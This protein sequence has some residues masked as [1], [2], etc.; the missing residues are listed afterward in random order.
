V[1]RL[2]PT[3]ALLLVI[4][5]VAG[6][7]TR[8]DRLRQ[9]H[10]DRGP[11]AVVTGA[12]DAWIEGRRLFFRNSG[13]PAAE[14]FQEIALPGPGERIAA[15]G[16][17][18]YVWLAGPR[19]LEFAAGAGG[20]GSPRELAPDNPAALA[21][22]ERPVTIRPQAAAGR[23]DVTISP[24]RLFVTNSESGTSGSIPGDSVTAIDTSSNQVIGT[25]G[26][27]TGDSPYD[28]TVLPDNSQAFTANF[29]CQNC[30]D[31]GVSVFDPA[32]LTAIKRLPAALPS[33]LALSPDGTRLYAGDDPILRTFDT[34]TGNQIAALDLVVAIQS[35]SIPSNGQ[36]LYVIGSD[37]RLGDAIS[38]ISAASPG[39]LA[40]RYTFP[41]GSVCGPSAMLPGD[42][43]L[44]VVCNNPPTVYVINIQSDGT[45]SLA[46]SFSTTRA[47]S[48]AFSPDGKKLYLAHFDSSTLETLDAAAGSRLGLV[49][50][51]SG[52]VT[53]LVNRAGT[54][55]YTANY[56]AN[57]V[58]V[59]DLAS[60]TVLAS[61]AVG[62][63]P[64]GLAL[65]HAP[66]VVSA[67]P[68]QLSFTGAAGQANPAPQN[69][70]LNLEGSGATWG[71]VVATESGGNWL[72]LSAVN[73]TFPATLQ[74][75][76]NLAGLAGGVYSGSITVSP[77]LA[78]TT[79]VTVPVTLAVSAASGG[80]AV[81][82]GGIVNAASFAAGVPVAAG[83]LVSLFGTSLGP[84]TGVLATG[85]PLPTLLAN[86]KVTMNGIAAP[87]IYTSAG[88]INCQVPVELAGQS[89]AQVVV[90][91]G[92]L[93][94]P[95][96]SLSLAPTG[97]GI[98]TATVNGRPQGAVLNKDFTLNTPANPARLGDI[99]QVFA[100][101]QGQVSNTPAN[102]APAP[103][104]P[105][106]TTPAPPVVLIGG[107]QADIA[108]S[109]LA[110]GFVGLWQIN[111]VVPATISAGDAVTVQIVYGNATSNI[112]TIAIT[113]VP[114]P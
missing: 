96:V 92:T 1:K 67:S 109:G 69:L 17:R 32:Q 7:Q 91:N 27:N 9:A 18:I 97:P 89:T 93:P 35:I 22:L 107:R 77:S 31:R 54:R 62:P 56:S 110:P 51:P 73:G 47:F 2:T 84:A 8:R 60:D 48:M 12:F 85:L 82:A 63:N 78:G 102:G 13:R 113:A 87:L 25:L 37:A 71:A 70:I 111:A 33:A 15:A 101:G 86:V 41:A 26:L 65:T 76:V 11:R 36:T 20:P 94:S 79:P 19:L 53:V 58:S 14:P 114:A 24:A 30:I 21:A 40:A 3:V 49:T 16:D 43:R 68:A 81:P 59:V 105:L 45:L 66:L 104:S 5:A 72:S 29:G 55:A 38:V 75:S 112:T 52:P 10:L 83:S 64:V 98:F 106:A 6:A 74:V 4:A 34:A 108:F 50:V 95:P 99:I 28:V 61:V 88:Q 90:Q 46:T 39:T 42:Q 44:Y 57:S 80:P 100:T 23:A 103:S